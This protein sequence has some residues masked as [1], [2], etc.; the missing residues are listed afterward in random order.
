MDFSNNRIDTQ[1]R[2]AVYVRIST[3]MQKTDRQV[4]ELVTFAKENTPTQIVDI[5]NSEGIPCPF[6]SRLKDAAEKRKDKGLSPKIYRRGD[7]DNM[8]WHA[9]NINRIVKNT[10]YIGKRHFTFYEPDPANPKPAYKRTDRR[11]LTE[12]EVDL[13][14]LR[15][16]DD[17]TFA[18][19]N[20]VIENRHLNKNVGVHRENLLKTLLIC[21]ECGSRASSTVL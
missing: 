10:V 12:F 4:E 2:T 11:I 19:A 9:N 16:V 6:W 18:Q 3:S 21:G 1:R 7:P 13:P 20:A 15:I 5:L 8:R 14:E 17:E